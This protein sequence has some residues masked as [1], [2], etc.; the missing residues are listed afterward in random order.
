MF[1]IKMVAAGAQRQDSASR[2]KG[3]RL[4]QRARSFKEDL[5][6]KFTQMR[7]PSARSSSPTK[8]SPRSKDK[9]GAQHANQETQVIRR[10]EK[11]V[12]QLQKDV[13]FALRYFQDVV[14]KNTLEMLPGSATIVLENILAILTL[15][16]NDMVN[17]QSS[18]L[19]LS[20]TNQVHQSLANLIKWADN[21]LLYGNQSHNKENVA[22]VVKGVHEAIKI[23]IQLAEEKRHN[24][25]SKTTNGIHNGVCGIKSDSPKRTSLP[26]IPLTPREREILEQTSFTVDDLQLA[27]TP[28]SGSLNNG[29][30]VDS[31]PP[32]KPPLPSNHSSTWLHG[33]CPSAGNM[34]DVIPPLPPKR[35]ATHSQ[36]ESLSSTPAIWNGSV[37]PLATSPHIVQF[38]NSFS[39]HSSNHFSWTKT[40]N[41]CDGNSNLEANLSDWGSSFGSSP[42]SASPMNVSA[43]SLDSVL[44]KSADDL[45][46]NTS[47]TGAALGSQFSSQ[48]WTTSPVFEG[49]TKTGDQLNQVQLKLEEFSCRSEEKT[50]STEVVSANH[51]SSRTWK[52]SVT[53]TRHTTVSESIVCTNGAENSVRLPPPPAIPPKKKNL[54]RTPSQYDNLPDLQVVDSSEEEHG[55]MESPSP[56]PLRHKTEMQS[57]CLKHL[58]TH[59]HF[60]EEGQP[61]PLPLKKKHIMAY[62]QMFGDYSEPNTN[63]FFRHS[64]HTYNLLQAQWRQQQSEISS[65]N[66]RSMTVVNSCIRS[67]SDEHLSS[68]YDSGSY[69]TSSV[70]SEESEILPPA[71]PPKRNRGSVA[72]SKPRLSTSSTNSLPPPSADVKDKLLSIEDKGRQ[73]NMLLNHSIDSRPE[74]KIRSEVEEDSECSPLDE[75]IVDKY[76]IHKK[77]GEEGPDIRGG[78]IDALIVRASKVNKNDFMYQEA[79][80]TTYR[81]FIT[82]LELVKKLLYRYNKFSI[83]SDMTRQRAA[84]NAFSLLVRVVDDIC[85]NDVEEIILQ[86]LMDFVYQLLCNGDLMLARALRKKILEKCESK[87][88]ANA[89]AVILLSSYGVTTRQS[90]LLDFKSEQLAEQMTLLD[91]DLFQKIEIPEVLIWAREQSEELSPNLTTFTEHFNKMSYWARSR[92]LDQDDAKDREKYVV[93]FIKI[94]KHLRKLNNF[95]SYLAILS[96]L[97]SAP[98]RRLEWQRHITEGLKEY[99]ELI[100]SSS[101]FRAYRQALAE[102]EPPCIPYIGL[103]LQ[104]LTFVH[105][106]NND[107]LSDPIVNFSKRWQQFNILD[108][109]RRFKKCNYH[110][111]RS[112]KIIAFFNNFDDYLC[113]ESMWQISESIKP[114][115]GK[116]KMDL[117]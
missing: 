44:N 39:A 117:M 98:I 21:V 30:T 72:S 7:S 46:T 12:L 89:T 15:L 37:S 13:Q 18:S 43:T 6:E 11:D 108:N 19:L 47:R 114:R 34:L 27:S 85:V 20:T 116:K 54:R 61:P 99:C 67:S 111:K 77:S 105:I 4:A 109:M 50:A 79:F 83:T 68:G 25:E 73:I 49:L 100:D 17:E 29:D 62:M 58:E 3:G 63:E 88:R 16:K 91:A 1:T 31:T 56:V 48:V 84:R 86:T 76:L 97:D 101:S 94:M 87:R 65:L 75:I 66:L 38:A 81:T 113:E 51:I 53:A 22:E 35:K 24:K 26:D 40:S 70:F 106:G 80:L 71:L 41:G 102:T 5:L 2:S 74:S 45:L 60:H 110:F 107:W 8:P 103:I 115:G 104:D 64:F 95:N 92:I 36:S 57:Y 23:L 14:D 69:K 78:T 33:R 32:P 93:K 10:N 90:I 82:P 52:S 96:A 59:K 9:N 112:E 28:Y 42:D 55:A